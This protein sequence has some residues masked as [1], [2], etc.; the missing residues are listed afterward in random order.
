MESFNRNNLQPGNPFATASLCG[1]KEEKTEKTSPGLFG[2]R[3]C[4]F[5]RATESGSERSINL[6]MVGN[7]KNPDCRF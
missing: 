5:T 6:E 3:A 7:F 4:F 1:A 2:F